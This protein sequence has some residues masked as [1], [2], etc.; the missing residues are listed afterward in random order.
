MRHGRLTRFRFQLQAH[1]RFFRI[2]KVANDLA[3]RFG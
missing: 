2:G 1:Q 3:D